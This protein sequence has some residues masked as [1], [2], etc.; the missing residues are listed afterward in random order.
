[1]HVEFRDVSFD[2]GRKRALTGIDWSFG[3]GVTGLLGPNG[4]GKSTLLSLLVTITSPA[5]GSVRIGGC[6]LSDSDGKAR[7]RT[8]LGFVPQRFT[9]VPEMRVRDTVAYA[10]WVNGL[11]DAQCDAAADAALALAGLVEKSRSRV[12]ALSGGQRQRLGIACALAHRPAVLVL[13]EPTVG[14]DPGQRL[15]VRKLIAE[16]GTERTVIISSHLLEDISQLCQQVGV[17]ADG[18]L[19][20]HGSVDELT[21]LIDTMSSGAEEQLGTAFER[22]YDSLIARLQGG[23]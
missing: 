2:Y 12:R 7:A 3:G 11:A 20:F 17:L 19:V 14:L 21:Q 8:L 1:M 18:R 4:A 16:L 15:R 13:D 6:D 10:G 5:S 22:A 23:E 9:L